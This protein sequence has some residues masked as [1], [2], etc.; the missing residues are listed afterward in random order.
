MIKIYQILFLKFFIKLL[1]FA[2]RQL[3]QL[4]SIIFGRIEEIS[5]YKN[6]DIKVIKIYPAENYYMPPLKDIEGNVHVKEYY[7][8]VP[9]ANVYIINNGLFIPGQ[10]EVYDSKSRV[11]KE[12]TAQKINPQK[13]TSKRKLLNYKKIKGNVLCLSL[14][15]LEENY[16]HF[17]IEY[18]ARWHIFKLSQLSFDYVDFNIKTKFQK[19]F[20]DLLNIPKEKLISNHFKKSTYRADAL[21]VPSLINN[22]ELVI[23]AHERK[24]CQKQYVPK[25]CKKIHEEFRKKSG[26]TSRIYISRSKANRRK[27]TN[28]KEVIKLVTKYG[29][30]KYDMEDLDVNDQIQLFNKAQIIISTTG[31]G[32]VNMVFCSKPFKLLEIYP[33]NFFDAGYRVLA[34]VLE[35]DYHYL[36]GQC[37]NKYATDP[38][39]EDLHIDCKKLQKW[40]YVNVN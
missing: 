19:Q 12:I 38:E 5:I 20:F 2:L 22:W 21:I 25:W 39:Y 40:L 1:R 28:E 23:M 18:L 33:K 6:K 8:P 13:N 32:L 29:F 31:A 26:A 15:G 37:L 11:L 7:H 10:L 36:I 24:H 4:D 14:S 3:R 16:Y 9:E 27:V 35:C 34:R 17:N 30:V